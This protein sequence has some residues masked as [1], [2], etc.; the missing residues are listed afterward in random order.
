MQY[1]IVLDKICISFTHIA[2]LLLQM[3]ETLC[4]QALILVGDFNHMDICWKDHTVSC[5]RSR[6]LLESIDDI[7]L[8]QVLDR[9][10]RGEALL[11]IL[12]TNAEE[13]IKGIKVRGSLGCSDHALVEFVIS[14]NVGLG[15]EWG[16][17]FGRVNFRLFKELLAK[18]SWDAVLKDKD[19]EESWLLFKDAFLRAQ[20]LSVPLN[21]KAGRVGRKL[22]WLSKDL[23]GQTEG[24]ERCKQALETKACHWEE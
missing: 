16:Q 1:Y 18:I 5:K 13:I 23:L 22:T 24:K 17:D 15:K 6:R 2:S 4:S 20:E 12:L 14:R 10:T 19:V 3:Q 21:K 7:F 8:Y 11:D 9:L